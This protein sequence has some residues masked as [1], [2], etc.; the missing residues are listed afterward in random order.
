LADCIAQPNGGVFSAPGIAGVIYGLNG[1]CHQ[2]ANRILSAANVELPL[3]FAQ[4]RA[5]RLTFRG[6]FGWNVAGQPSN[7]RW[8][9]RSVACAAQPQSGSI[10]PSSQPRS[11]S[12]TNLSRGSGLMNFDTSGSFDPRSELS[13]LLA[14]GLSYSVDDQT[15]NGLIEM[16]ARLHAEQERLVLL[17]VSQEIS[18]E[19]YIT[20]L[21]SAMTEAT[22]T[23]EQLLGI[24]EFH[25]VFGEFRVY[26]VVDVSA[27]VDGHTPVFR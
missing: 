6:P 9:N 19:Q 11:S 20:L 23:G 15:F 26:D 8:P 25:K 17:L 18:R 16:Q 4:I 7:D 14:A 21:D 5:T 2:M 10:G 27:F 22:R 24:D 13:T 12:T 1:V 3:T